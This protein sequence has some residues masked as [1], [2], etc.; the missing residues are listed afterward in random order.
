MNFIDACNEAIECLE[1]WCTAKAV[2]WEGGPGYVPISTLG[3][4]MVINR[5]K[6]ALAE[7][8]VTVLADENEV[9]S[10]AQVNEWREHYRKTL[11]TLHDEN[12]ALRSTASS[13]SAKLIAKEAPRSLLEKFFNLPKD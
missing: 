3:T 10:A 8:K 12:N 9:Y 6:R 2:R 5:I 1:M 7:N 11:A 13:L 4:R